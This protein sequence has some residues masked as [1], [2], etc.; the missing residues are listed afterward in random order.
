M[1][2]GEYFIPQ[3]EPWLDE[4][5]TEAV[6]SYLKSGGW[7]TEFKYTRELEKNIAAFT[8]SSFCSILPNGTL[9]LTAALLACGL[10]RGDEVIVPDFTMVASANAVILAGG[11]VVFA[12]IDSKNLCLDFSEFK[13]AIT[14]KTKAVILVSINGRSPDNMEEFSSFCREKN[15]FLIE[16]AAQSL[17]SF[18]NGRHLGTFGDFGSFSFSAPKVITTG[19]GGALITNNRELIKK[20]NLL[21]DFGRAE[22]GSDHYLAMGWNLKFTDLQ[23]IIGLEQMKKISWRLNRKKEI[24]SLYKKE[25]E[26]IPKISLIPTNL[27]EVSPWFIDILV[28]DNKREELISFLKSKNIGSR[29]F[30][31]AL[32][33]EPVY[34]RINEKYPVSEKIAKEG[35]WLPSSSKLTDKEITFICNQIKTFFNHA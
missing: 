2:L 25:L 11:N 27:E 30:Y 22:G 31:P 32:H 18:K 3:M 34:D 4:K 26:N 24:Y 6:S 35:L 8:N 19:Q 14:P 10:K 16:D 15:I 28:K 21:R 20:I 9:S 17:G 13:K 29:P 23:A 1:Q 7:L 12:D 5:E 33:L